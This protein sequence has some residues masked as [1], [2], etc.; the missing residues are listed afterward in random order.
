MQKATLIQKAKFKSKKLF[1][2][3]PFDFLILTSIYSFFAQI[4]NDRSN[5]L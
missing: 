4:Y 1:I 5:D 3:K 2:R